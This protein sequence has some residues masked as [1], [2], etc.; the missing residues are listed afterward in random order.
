MRGNLCVAQ[1]IL[2]PEPRRRVSVVSRFS[3]SPSPRPFLSLRTVPN[4][5][6]IVLRWTGPA[7]PEKRRACPLRRLHFFG[8]D[9]WT[10]RDG[11]RE[12]DASAE[13]PVARGKLCRYVAPPAFPGMRIFAY[14]LNGLRL[15]GLSYIS[16]T[17]RILLDNTCRVEMAVSRSRQRVGVQVTRQFFEG[18]FAQTSVKPCQVFWPLSHSKQTVEAH[19]KCQFFALCF[20]IPVSTNAPASR[21]KPPDTRSAKNRIAAFTPRLTRRGVRGA[22]ECRR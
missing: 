5:A 14:P 1:T 7:C 9:E 11:Y 10:K 6:A 4:C 3:R 20:S 13:S 17:M 16:T 19:N 18:S 15:G 2:R 22:G 8:R 21:C 12:E